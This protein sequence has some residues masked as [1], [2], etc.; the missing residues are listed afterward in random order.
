MARE[1]SARS[2]VLFFDPLPR[3]VLNPAAPPKLLSTPAEKIR[4]MREAGV[5]ALVQLPFDLAL[6]SLSPTDFVQQYF[7]DLAGFRLTGV[8]CG[9]EWRFGA[10]NVGDVRLLGELL[11]AHGVQLR[12]VPPVML[13][14]EKISSSRIREAVAIGDLALA[15][16]ML[17]R[18]YSIAG[19]VAHG[20]GIASSQLHTPTANLVDERLQLPPYGVYAARTDLG[21]GG[22]WPGIV[23]IGDAPTVRGVGNN[24][25][26]VE[27][28]LFDFQGSLYGKEVR[29]TPVK[30]L[31]ESRVFPSSAALQAQIQTDLALARQTL[32][33]EG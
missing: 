6:A 30:F 17:G 13:G 23:Y 20:A 21:E 18:P 24:H 4:Q 32:Q 22:H 27:L 8:C 33:S 31:R 26:V 16:R 9:E 14:D 11:G 12:A 25:P 29:V 10:G 28:H 15:E 5:E 2:A 1:F 7:F 3:Q 19:T